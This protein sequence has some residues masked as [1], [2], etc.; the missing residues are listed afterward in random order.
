[1]SLLSRLFKRG[2][3]KRGAAFS[4]P[5][6]PEAPFFVIGD[7]HGCHAQMQTLE[8]QMEARDTGAMRI[9][10]GDYTD[11][12]EASAPVLRDLFAKRNDPKM[13]CLAGN[14]EDMLL[15]FIDQPETAGARWLKFGG[16]QT[17]ASFGVRGL[18]AGADGAALSAG[19]MALSAAMGPDM[20]GWLRTLPTQWHSGNVA[21]VHAGADPALPL[22]MQS[23]KTLKWGHPD[24]D[25]VLRTDDTW[26]VHGHTIVDQATAQAGKIAV[27]TGAYATGRLTAAYI[28][29]GDVQFLQT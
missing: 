11:R 2:A 17:V 13:V 20:L 8:A 16:L 22:S 5:L 1:M 9:Y 15:K 12:G 29:P 26:V 27:D 19:A 14:H 21:V 4:A 6:A 3:A 28:T 24:F 10:V 7:I 25:R 23:E 18:S